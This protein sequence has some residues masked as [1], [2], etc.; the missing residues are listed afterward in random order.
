MSLNNSFGQK[1]GFKVEEAKKIEDNDN[2][3]NASQNNDIFNSI[4][5]EIENED[6]QPNDY[7]NYSHIKVKISF[8][9]NNLFN[10][11]KQRI[12]NNQMKFFFTL[13]HKSNNKYSKLVN[14]EILYM[15]IE[16]SFKRLKHIWDKKRI[17]LINYTF[18][19]IKNYIV[20]KKNYKDYDSKKNNEIKN[21]INEIEENFKKIEKK[22]KYKTEEVNNIKN[23]V[24]N[25]KREMDEI[26]EKNNNLEE[27]Y[28]QLLGKNN[29]LKEII[30]LSRQKSAK[31][32][33]ENNINEEKIIL[34]LQNKIKIKE[35]ENEKQLAYC[36]LFYQSMSEMLSKYESKFD[37][38][39]S[40]INTTNQNI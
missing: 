18:I 36:E 13:K 33:Y 30:S 14:S 27:K 34:D 10:Y 16:T 7:Y 38:I 3:D 2:I 24:E 5:I 37:T 28:N 35:K 20:L 9:L 40:T 12:N 19:R 23:K 15:L 29:E 39:K 32:N 31:Y 25:Q 11:I 22:Y 17:D 8:H 4:P 21:K 1:N 6:N 26:K